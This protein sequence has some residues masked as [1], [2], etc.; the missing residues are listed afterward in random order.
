MPSDS[1][2]DIWSYIPT[3]K[4]GSSFLHEAVRAVRTDTKA[5]SF[6]SKSLE[7][8]H[9]L[10]LSGMN[11]NARNNFLETPL[12]TAVEGLMLST[13]PAMFRI[14]EKLISLLK[15]AG[16]LVDVIVEEGAASPRLR[17]IS[18]LRITPGFVELEGKDC[19]HVVGPHFYFGLTV[20]P[21]LL[22]SIAACDPSAASRALDFGEDPAAKIFPSM[23]TALH[24]AI[25]MGS[26]EIV[27]LLL[28]VKDME[29]SPADH[30]GLTP[31]VMAAALGHEACMAELLKAGASPN[32]SAVAPNMARIQRPTV[33][34]DYLINM[35][36]PICQG[37]TALHE[38]VK[39][40]NAKCV[41][42][43]LS[44]GANPNVMDRIGNTPLLFA[45]AILRKVIIDDTIT[46]PASSSVKPGCHSSEVFLC[47]ISS[48][49]QSSI[50][51]SDSSSPIN[52]PEE[53]AAVAKKDEGAVDELAASYERIVSV[54]LNHKNFNHSNDISDSVLMNAVSLGSES[55]S[56]MLLDKGADPSRK[57]EYGTTP[58][59][60][61]ASRGDVKLL[62]LLVVFVSGKNQGSP[63][64]SLS[65]I[66]AKDANGSTPL[67]RAAYGGHRACVTYLIKVGANL[68]LRNVHGISGIEAIL[69]H[70]HR[71]R[72]F[73]TSI[74]DSYVSCKPAHKW[75]GDFVL[76]L[77]ISALSPEGDV[78]Q[79]AV[80]NSLL[81][82][83]VLPKGMQ[84]YG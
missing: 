79:T 39:S 10:I 80:M 19:Y 83:S 28:S 65:V 63:E 47:E 59:H 7:I 15:D 35:P 76:E 26:R 21:R 55:V 37:A 71:S 54:L 5:V 22:D 24:L 32:Q 84:R 4:D 75:E 61:A 8:V 20:T 72:S 60:E 23:L 49:T 11:V 78:K 69:L 50:R 70:V 67:H 41:E 43:L 40:N 36:L 51:T 44:N 81:S 73:L 56:K 64:V 62:R 1:R 25:W 57:N 38:A 82:S 74:L 29:S 31:L 34:V 13:V 12:L 52:F 53:G 3:L 6:S 9:V 58:L 66:N 46:R 16:A 2:S 27:R 30:F 48:G 42:I 68:S 33:R 18:A 17:T 77:D 14:H 45:G